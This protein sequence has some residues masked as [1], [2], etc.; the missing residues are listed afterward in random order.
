MSASSLRWIARSGTNQHLKP[1]QAHFFIQL[2]ATNQNPQKWRENLERFY[3]LG[4]S[5][6]SQTSR[7]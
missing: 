6:T 4:F 7:A 3:I 2:F 1:H 5:I